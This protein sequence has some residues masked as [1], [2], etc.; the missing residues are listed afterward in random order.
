MLVVV[1]VVIGYLLYHLLLMIREQVTDPIL[2]YSMVFMSGSLFL[3]GIFVFL[4]NHE[5]NTKATLVFSFF[6]IFLIFSETFRGIGYYQLAFSDFSNNFARVLLIISLGILV[7]YSFLEKND[8]EPI[9][10]LMFRDLK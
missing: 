2:F 1:A 9:S 10:N 7:Y 3:L 5:Y 4:Y 8:D 6:G